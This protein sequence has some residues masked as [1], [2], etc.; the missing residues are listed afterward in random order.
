MEIATGELSESR[1][2]EDRWDPHLNS[3]TVEDHKTTT[4]TVLTRLLRTMQ[5]VL[6]DFDSSRKVTLSESDRQRGRNR[7]RLLTDR[8]A[9]FAIP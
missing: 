5:R 7:N 4:S 8:A 9:E 2:A 1:A 3:A 6:G